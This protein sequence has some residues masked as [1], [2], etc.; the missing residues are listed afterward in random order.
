M[1]TGNWFYDNSMARRQAQEM[2]AALDARERKH[3]RERADNLRRTGG[4]TSYCSKCGREWRDFYFR[5]RTV[6]WAFVIGAVLGSFVA[7]AVIGHAAVH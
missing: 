6:A 5:F 1:S 4:A 2:A 3:V 7:S